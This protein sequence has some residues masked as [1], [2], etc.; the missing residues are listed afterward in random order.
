MAWEV[1]ELPILKKMLE[2]EAPAA[3]KAEV[4]AVATQIEVL[5]TMEVEAPSFAKV[6]ALLPPGSRCC[7]CIH[8]G[9]Q[10]PCGHQDRGSQASPTNEVKVL[11]PPRM[12]Q[13]HGPVTATTHEVRIPADVKVKVRLSPRLRYSCYHQD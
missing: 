8:H 13:Y 6:E 4:P 11:L 5:P 1:V 12:S 7:C 2:V 9:G 3:T 10:H